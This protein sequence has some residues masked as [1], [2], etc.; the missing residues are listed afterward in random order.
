MEKLNVVFGEGKPMFDSIKG[1]KGIL[2]TTEIIKY[3]FRFNFQKAFKDAYLGSSAPNVPL[4]E[5]ESGKEVRLLDFMKKDRPLV[6][7]F[8][9]C[10]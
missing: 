4:F 7:N 8:G 2:G 3:M 1:A 10:T 9:S 6:V 5:L